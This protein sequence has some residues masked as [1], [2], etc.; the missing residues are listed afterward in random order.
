MKVCWNNQMCIP[1]REYK[2]SLY[3]FGDKGM[4]V[5]QEFS[6]QGHKSSILLN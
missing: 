5:Y 2:S 1:L 6:F 4:T 3:Y